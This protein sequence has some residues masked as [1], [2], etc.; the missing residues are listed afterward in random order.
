M[1]AESGSDED[2]AIASVEAGARFGLAVLAERIQIREGE[3]HEV[4]GDRHRRART[5]GPHDKTSLVMAVLDEPGSLLRALQPLAAR[6]INLHKLESRPDARA[7]FE[8]V[9]Y[10][11]VMAGGRRSRRWSRRWRRSPATRR[12]CGS[13]ARTGRPRTP[14]SLPVA[15]RRHRMRRMPARSPAPRRTLEA[16]V[17]GPAVRAGRRGRRG[18]ALAG[19]GLGRRRSR[20]RRQPVG[21]AVDERLAVARRD[22]LDGRALAERRSDAR[23]DQHDVPGDH[24]VPGQRDAHLLRRGAGPDGSGD[25][26]ELPGDRRALLARRP[27]PHGARTWCGTGWTGQPNVIV[28]EDGRI[29]VRDRRV[30][31]RLPLPRRPHRTADAAGAA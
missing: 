19:V 21:P 12:C 29:E 30:R 28:H 16:A 31:R 8:Y 11:D 2:A 10:V 27:T 14:P 15:H 9:I 20:G 25:P 26:L 23:P 22:R 5:S 13:S 17:P 1:I 3:L 18:D 7:P 24:D 4:R 6:G